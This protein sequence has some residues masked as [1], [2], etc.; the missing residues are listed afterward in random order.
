MSGAGSRDEDRRRPKARRRRAATD[1]VSSALVQL[2]AA[3]ST[4]MAIPGAELELK[5]LLTGIPD[6]ELR[7][8]FMDMFSEIKDARGDPRVL[9]EV[10]KRISKKFSPIDPMRDS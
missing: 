5:W 10:Q 1:R 6:L 2:Y 3:A 8:W 9:E 7:K 4:V